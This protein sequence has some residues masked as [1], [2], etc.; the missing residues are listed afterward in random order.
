MRTSEQVW[1]DPDMAAKHR[2]ALKRLG[3]RWLLHPANRTAR[4]PIEVPE[5]LR[6]ELPSLLR[7][8]AH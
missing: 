6:R 8:Q 2:D 4:T 1:P 3:P 5:C 7:T